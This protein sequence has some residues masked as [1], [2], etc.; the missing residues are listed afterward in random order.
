[1]LLYQDVGLGNSI[2]ALTTFAM[3]YHAPMLIMAIRRGGFGE[4]NSAVHTYSENAIAM[5][6]AMQVKAFVLDYRV[7]LDEWP[8]AISQAYD[9]SHL[10]HRPVIVF[11]NLKE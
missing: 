8:R 5:V 7:P 11:I 3:A 6:E 10:T 1:M 2:V 4:Y 9:Y